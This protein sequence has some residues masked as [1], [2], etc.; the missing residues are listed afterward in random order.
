MPVD[1]TLLRIFCQN[2]RSIRRSNGITQII[3]AERLGVSQSQY[4]GIE[5]GKN[6]PT[7]TTV[8][9]CANALGVPVGELLGAGVMIGVKSAS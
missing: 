4:A 5:A 6:A 7:L 8:E 3:M 1:S 2:L 9:R